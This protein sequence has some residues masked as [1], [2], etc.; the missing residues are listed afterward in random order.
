ML[1]IALVTAR[2]ALPLDED[3]PPLVAALAR[4]GARAETPVWD[5]ADVDWRRYSLAV[6]RSTWDYAERLAEFLAWAERCAEQTRLL[7]ALPILR[8]SIDKHYL[9]DLHARGVPVVPTRYV[10][11][12]ARARQELDVFLQRGASALHAGRCDRFDEF[13]VKPAIGAGSRD[14]ARYRRDDGLALEHLSRLLAAGRSVLLQPYLGR[15]DEHGET[16]V[17][18]L[19]GRYSH[20][21]RKGPLLNVGARLVPGLVAPEQITPREPDAAEREVAAAAHAAVPGRPPAYARI[22]L[23]RGQEGLPVVLELELAEP[24]MYFGHAAGSADRFARLLIEQAS[25]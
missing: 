15:V 14:A 3:L 25:A 24:S 7:N 22:D 6:L 13:V 10:P 21:F 20:A 18:Y 23:I 12:G 17:V 4:A 11:S 19:G 16:A 1:P 8:W 9:L 5:D 2:A